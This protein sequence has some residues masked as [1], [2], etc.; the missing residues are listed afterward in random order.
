MSGYTSCSTDGIDYVNGCL[1]SVSDAFWQRFSIEFALAAKESVFFLG[2]GERSD[3]TFRPTSYFTVYELPNLNPPRVSDVVTMVVHRKGK[4]NLHP[5]NVSRHPL[6]DLF[7]AKVC[8][9]CHMN[10]YICVLLAFK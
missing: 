7:T 5:S 2:Y 1:C 10:K 3:G 4:G 9:L 6:L 8:D